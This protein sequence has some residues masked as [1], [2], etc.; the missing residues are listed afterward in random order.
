MNAVIRMTETVKIL[1]GLLLAIRSGGITSALVETVSVTYYGSQT[2][3]KHMATTIDMGDK[4]MVTPFDH[5]MVGEVAEAL[6]K[7]GLMAYTSGKTNVVVSSNAMSGAEREKAKAQIKRLGEQ[8]K[9]S[10]R[11]IRKAYRQKIDDTLPED[12]RI[13]A[14]VEIQNLTAQH[15][16]K[17]DKMIADKLASLG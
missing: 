14:E 2:P 6:R 3:I 16:V 4:V 12:D 9:I 13:K 1:D 8:S 11:N 5:K 7:A 17:I 10:I 15:E